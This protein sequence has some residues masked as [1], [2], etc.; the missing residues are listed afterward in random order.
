M[1]GLLPPDVSPSFL[2]VVAAAMGRTVAIALAGTVLAVVLAVPLGLLATPALFRRGTLGGEGSGWWAA[3][4][5]LAHLGARGLLRIFRSVPDLLWAL[6]FVVAVGLGPLAGTLAVGVSYGGVLGRVYAD[7][8]EEV[9]PLPAEALA[10]AGGRRTSIVLFALVPQALAGLV[11][12]TLYSLECAIRAASVLGFVG[13]GGI[14]QELQMSMRL[15]EYHQ[16][17]TLLLAL[18]LLMGIGEWVSRAL[19]RALGKQEAGGRKWSP[20]GRAAAWVG[21]A[22]VL[23]ASFCAGS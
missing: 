6:L 7:L 18:F 22:A 20:A 9:D 14:G 11:G 2:L 12:Y 5:L 4:L 16:V 3:P 8:L 1:R 13:A 19:R 17:S 10:A 23:S 15:F 21:A